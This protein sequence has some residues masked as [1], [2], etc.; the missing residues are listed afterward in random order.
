MSEK[1]KGMSE[2]LKGIEYGSSLEKV[3]WRVENV[4]VVREKLGRKDNCMGLVLNDDGVYKK[5]K[6]RCG[7]G[8]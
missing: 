2:K 7:N 6:G 8:G 3:D 4:E 1:V 5:V